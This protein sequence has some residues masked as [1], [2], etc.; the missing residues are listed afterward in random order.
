MVSL[1]ADRDRA[2]DA[3]DAVVEDD[4]L[5]W[6]D[7]ERV[8]DVEIC[9]GV[10]LPAAYLVRKEAAVE[11]VPKV[12]LVVEPLYV[13]RVRI[14]QAGKSKVRPELLEQLLRTRIGTAQPLLILGEESLARH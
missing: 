13:E 2:V 1:H 11:P 8:A 12:Q 3:L 14:A 9:F 7:I 10:G 6:R 5:V 4:D